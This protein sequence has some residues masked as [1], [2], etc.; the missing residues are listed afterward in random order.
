M[1]ILW[2]GGGI[3]MTGL[4]V[5]VAYF[6]L[7]TSKSGLLERV[8]SMSVEEYIDMF[9][10]RALSSVDGMC[11]VFESTDDSNSVSDIFLSKKTGSI[12]R[13]SLSSDDREGDFDSHKTRIS[14]I[15]EY[16][17]FD[18][19]SDLFD[20]ERGNYASD[21]FLRD[22]TNKTLEHISESFDGGPSNGYSYHGF[23]SAEGRYVVF[24]S[25]ASNLVIGDMNQASDI[26]LYD[27]EEES[28]HR[29]SLS[30]RGAEGAGDSYKPL[31]SPDGEYVLFLS[32]APN[33]IEHDT[34][35]QTDIF[36]IKI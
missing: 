23:V 13:V 20:G 27:R 10:S 18:S 35:N 15:C 7:H 8:S 22:L 36:R 16:V 9:N 21:V 2:I 4:V 17:I 1:R 31:I 25:T 5:V 12:E 6:F 14:A 11:S 30:K 19:E 28:M 24:D 3:I 33:L 26:F 32:D 34:N 29:L